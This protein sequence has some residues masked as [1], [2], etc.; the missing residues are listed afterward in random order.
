MSLTESDIVEAPVVEPSGPVQDVLAD[1]L[2][3]TAVQAKPKKSKKKKKKS[4]KSKATPL[5]KLE[6]AIADGD[7]GKIFDLMSKVEQSVRVAKWRDLS[8]AN[9]ASV[10]GTLSY[11]KCKNDQALL[12][13]WFDVT[14]DGEVDTLRKLMKARFNMDFGGSRDVDEVDE[15]WDAPSLRR[16]YTIL[17]A[18]PAKHVEGNKW[19]ANWARTEGDGAAGGYYY[20][21]DKE[22]AMQFGTDSMDALNKAADPEDPLYDVIRFNK[23][24]RHEVGHA[25]DK[26]IGGAKAF[27]IGNK[28]GGNW[29]EHGSPGAKLVKTMVDK[30]GGEIAGWGSSKQKRAIMKAIQDSLSERKT[31]ARAVV[32]ALDFWD[33]TDGPSAEDKT[34]L[35]TDPVFGAIESNGPK[36]NPWYNHAD[37]GVA[38]G[39]RVYQESYANNWTSYDQTAWDKKVSQYQFRAPGEW[40][41][42]AYATYYEPDGDGNV[43][44]LLQ[45]RD[46]KA[47][48]WFDKNVHSK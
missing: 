19:L 42:E 17:Q 37:G 31:D 29:K 7:W 18:L 32:G 13:V 9:R 34:K 35:L 6:R 44:T 40:F 28:A 20:D 4:K 46:P 12:K 48:K 3:T 45:G 2:D 15:P 26:K 38:L 24:A 30:S 14:P 47:K 27:C 8:L 5:E 16:C 21:G 36:V 39:G 43:G 41:A 25:V 22:S 10:A 1:P 33:E 23:V 11:T